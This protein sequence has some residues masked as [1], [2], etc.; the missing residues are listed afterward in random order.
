MCP[1]IPASERARLVACTA[2]FAIKTRC[3][4]IRDL[5]RASGTVHSSI[6]SDLCC[7][8]CHETFRVFSGRTFT[9]AGRLGAGPAPAAAPA[10]VPR[11]RLPGSLVPFI[12]RSRKIDST[13]SVLQ[14][15]TLP[16]DSDLEVMFVNRG[17]PVVGSLRRSSLPASSS[18]SGS[19]T[20][21][22]G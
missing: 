6:C 15:F 8:G 13:G 2:I 9:F 20:G 10:Q 22:A 19:D 5:S 21:S 14:E 12:A 1:N 17:E 18:G 7:R 11:Q 16:A 4:D 3:F